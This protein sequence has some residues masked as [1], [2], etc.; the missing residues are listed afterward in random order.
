MFGTPYDEE[1]YKKGQPCIL[2]RNV[3]F[4]SHVPLAVVIYQCGLSRDLTLFDAGDATEV[5]EKGITL[6]YVLE[7]WNGE[8]ATDYKA[9]WRTE[10]EQYASVSLKNSDSTVVGSYHACTGGVFPREDSIT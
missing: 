3:F 10:G 9:Q 5:G 4:S 8:L 2:E 6:R 7:I 1:R